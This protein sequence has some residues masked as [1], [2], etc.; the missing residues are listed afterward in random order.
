M[1]LTDMNGNSENNLDTQ[2]RVN[3]TVHYVVVSKNEENSE[4]NFLGSIQK[5]SEEKIDDN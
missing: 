2:V 4:T 5:R 1:V 3:Y